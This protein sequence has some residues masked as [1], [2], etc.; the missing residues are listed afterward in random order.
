MAAKKVK[1]EVSSF[2][3]ATKDKN[4]KDIVILGSGGVRTGVDIAKCIA[5]GSDLAGLAAPFAEVALISDEK[6]G[7]L[8]ERLSAE[9]KIAMFGIGAR[10][11]LELKNKKPVSV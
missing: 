8:I 9:L 2:A 10:N 7:I 11:I 5:L 6:V 4:D 1:D 3:K